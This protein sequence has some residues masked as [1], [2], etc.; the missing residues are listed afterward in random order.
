M[1]RKPFKAIIVGGSISGLTLALAFEKADIDYVL[2]E[3]GDS[4]SPEL[5]ASIGIFC[6]GMRVMDQLGLKDT[7]KERTEPMQEVYQYTGS[8]KLF[9]QSSILEKLEERHG[10]SAT[11]FERRNLLK[12]MYE[13]QPHPSKLLTGKHVQAIE[14]DENGVTVTTKDGG[15][16][17]GDIVIGADGVW[18]TVRQSMWKAMERDGQTKDLSHDKQGKHRT[19]I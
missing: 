10:Y 14:D 15:V 11:F 9:F 5:G 19:T 12:I 2:L 17:K 18:S 16:Y 13:A 1:E 6:N 4:F 3:K 7:I 8:G